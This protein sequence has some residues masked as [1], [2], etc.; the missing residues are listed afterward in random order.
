[1]VIIVLFVRN[2]W[3]LKELFEARIGGL[4]NERTIGVI[5]GT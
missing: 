5:G 3:Y 2:S 4:S 1:V